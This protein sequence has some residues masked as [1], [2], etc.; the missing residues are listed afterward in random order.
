M[1]NFFKKLLAF[2]TSPTGQMI[3]KVAV[4]VAANYV[5]NPAHKAAATAIV[6]ALESE[7]AP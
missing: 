1:S 3:G 5:K 7:T 6:N 4:A 2:I